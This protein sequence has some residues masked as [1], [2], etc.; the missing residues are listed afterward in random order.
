MDTIQ[1]VQWL[2]AN[3]LYESAEKTSFFLKKILT[4]CF[5][6]TDEKILIVGDQGFD[7]NRIAPI[8]SGAYYLAAKSLNI[9]TK[10]VLQEFKPRGTN[11]DEEVVNALSGLPEKNVVF[12]NMSDKVGSL[13]DLGKSFRKFCEKKKHRWISALSLGD[14][15]TSKLGNVIEAI[16][17]D[18]KPMQAVHQR[19][20]QILDDGKEIK[21]TSKA[22]TNLHYNIDGMKAIAADGNYKLPGTGGNM[23]AG[24]VYTPCNGKGVDGKVV[25]DGSSRNHQH[26]LVIKEPITLKIEEGSITEING[27]EEAK[28]LEATLKWAEEKATHPKSVYRVGEFGIGLNPKAKIIGSTLVDE[29]ALGTAHIGIGSNY[30]FGGSIYAI[31]HLDQIFKAPEIKVDGKKLEI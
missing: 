29:K 2:K 22:G 19:I 16:D 15:D 25:I 27:G 11:A 13:G 23:P 8:L 1:A 4:P 21:A 3:S 30:W 14:L 18:Y 12:V 5:G 28:K 20:K 17:V 26:T 24:E 9:D 7:N 6:I 10:L 31:I